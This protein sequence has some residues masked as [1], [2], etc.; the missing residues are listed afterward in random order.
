[1]SDTIQL[2]VLLGRPNVP[3]LAESQLQYLAIR[4]AS[5]EARGTE[6][7]SWPLNLVL[8]IDNSASMHGDD[9]RID[10]ALRAARQV[11]DQLRPD[12]RVS[13][14]AFSDEARVILES[15]AASEKTAIHRALQSVGALHAGWTWMAKG[16]RLAGQEVGR[17]LSPNRTSRV[18]LLTD[19]ITEEEETCERIALN[20]VTQG[21]TFSTFGVGEDWN[22]PLLARIAE[23]GRGHWHYVSQAADIAAAFVQELA[24]LQAT[25]FRNVTV[26]LDL[27][28]DIVVREA[29]E[30]EPEV[31]DLVVDDMDPRRVRL[32]VGEL[33]RADPVVL[34]ATLELP[35]RTAGRYKIADVTVEATRPG[36]GFP[37]PVGGGQGEGKLFQEITAAAVF[38]TYTE[39]MSQCWQEAQVL[40]YVD[41]QEVVRLVQKGTQLAEEGQAEEASRMLGMAAVI[42]ERGGDRKKTRLVQEA[43]QELGASGRISK[44]TRLTM[45]DRAR[46]TRIMTAEDEID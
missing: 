11:V 6:A 43:L 1:M 38:V 7:T 4:L 22:Q 46:K 5:Q 2:E 3:V 17:R 23:A 15:T 13:I 44:K 29:R 42:A 12:D 19:G 45:S 39:D 16:M 33:A 27:K 36:D 24:G 34:L 9:R 14:I 32:R 35:A 21:I 30:V 26:T 25:A 28:K 10:H 40:R 20:G 8:V 18:L 41:Q 37:L 31:A